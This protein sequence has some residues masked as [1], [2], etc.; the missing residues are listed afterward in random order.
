MKVLDHFSIPY[1]G[2]KNGFHIFHF[3]VDNDFF[4]EFDSSL[5]KKGQFKVTMELDKRPDMAI[6]DISCI[7]SVTTSCD[8]CLSDFD[9]PLDAEMQLHIKYGDENQDNDEVIYITAET[10]KVNFAQYIYEIITISLP[11][12]RMHKEIKD[13]DQDVVSK[14]QLDD[15]DDDE[16]ANGLWDALKDIKLN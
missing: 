2:L 8:R 3:E 14:M 6:A 7:G 9:L 5:I 16:P 13:C 11:M 15:Q 4:G 1:L 10:S 12:I